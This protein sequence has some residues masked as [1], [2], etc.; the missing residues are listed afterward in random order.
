MSLIILSCIA[1]LGTVFWV[2]A[3]R[4]HYRIQRRAQHGHIMESKAADM[5][6]KWGFRVIERNPKIEY[7]WWIDG[8]SVDTV[9]EADYLVRA[10]G[11]TWLV[12]VKTGRAARPNRR[13]TRRQ[14]LE[15]ATYGGADGLYLLD[16]DE[17]SLELI[18]FPSKGARR[19]SALRWNR[20]FFFALGVIIGLFYA[21]WD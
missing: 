20:V 12:E 8:E 3:K 19:H 4:Q 21:V 16:A 10:R 15:Y 6:K 11:K 13:E 5:L 7:T 1:I 14:L 17:E 2:R 9:V 18:E